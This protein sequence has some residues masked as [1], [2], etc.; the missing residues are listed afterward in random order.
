MIIKSIIILIVL[1]QSQQAVGQMNTCL[2]PSGCSSDE[3]CFNIVPKTGE[4]CHPI[5]PCYE[6]FSK[7]CCLNTRVAFTTK[8]KMYGYAIILDDPY[9]YRDKGKR[10]LQIWLGLPYAKPPTRGNNLRFMEPMQPDYVDKWDATYYRPSCPQ[11]LDRLQG[12][13]NPVADEDC[14]YLNIFVTNTTLDEAKSNVYP[15]LVFIHGGEHTY[16]SAQFTPGHV[17]AQTNIMVVTVQ[18][19]LNAFGYLRLEGSEATGNYGLMDQVQALRY[20]QQEA[21]K[22]RGDR[23]RVT[24]MGHGSGAGDVALHSM[25]PLSGMYA[26]PLFHR[27]IWLS[28]SDLM[29]GGFTIY[30]GESQRYALE[31]AVKTACTNQEPGEMLSCLRQRTHAELAGAASDSQVHERSWLGKP[32]SPTVDGKFILDTPENLRSQGRF[33]QTRVIGG[34]TWDDGA[35]FTTDLP[36]VVENASLSAALFKERIM[37]I[38]LAVFPHDEHAIAK[39]IE[40]EYT[41]WAATDN[42]TARLQM[43]RDLYSDRYYGSGLIRSLRFH[44]DKRPLKNFT[45]MY[46]F[47]YRSRN[48][49]KTRY[50]G[51]YHG[52]DLQYI[53]GLPYLNASNWTNLGIQ[54]PNFGYADL[55]MNMTDYMMYFISNFVIHGN[56]TPQLVRNFTWDSFR[57]NNRT[58]FQLNIQDNFENDFNLYQDYRTYHYAFWNNFFPDLVVRPARMTTI[59][60]TPAYLAQYKTSMFAL[61]GILATIVVLIAGLSIVLCRLMRTR[62]TT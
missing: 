18:Y 48:D 13:T 23:T 37:N 38:S 50:M 45:Q 61:G 5:M 17:L 35:Q 46:V 42:N 32:W 4:I 57:W 6:P 40:F 25:S 1:L 20:L 12:L 22:F 55:D 62:Q 3:C 54:R 36:G 44:A 34:I 10:F 30:P 11:P 2:K 29:W 21:E 43:L 47:K 9:S 51:A 41:D 49:P 39:A 53:F 14:L 27:A 15:I 24:L 60:P 7:D 56:A 8:G 19:R 28:G 52:S 59:M 16:G 33:A 58:Y 26:E 31:L